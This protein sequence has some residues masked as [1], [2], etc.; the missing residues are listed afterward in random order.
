MDEIRTEDGFI[1]RKKLIQVLKEK[2]GYSYSNNTLNRDLTALNGNNTFVIDMATYNYSETMESLFDI[3][4]YV[5]S[6]ARDMHEK[7]WTNSK[8]V[9]KIIHSGEEE[10]VIEETVKT[11]EIAGPHLKA[12][13]IM[14]KACKI[15][16]DALEG[17]VI[18]T[19]TA[20]MLK[21]FQKI[22]A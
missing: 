17:D 9:R 16:F 2:H 13:D 11:E 3:M 6:E 18:N 7:K 15:M 10:T 1:T 20:L 21:E 19:A 4:K 22:K 14:S 5:I 12:L 8:I